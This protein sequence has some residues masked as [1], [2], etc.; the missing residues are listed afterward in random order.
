MMCGPG[1]PQAKRIKTPAQSVDLFPTIVEGAGGSGA[2]EPGQHGRSLWEIARGA[3]IDRTVFAEFHASASKNAS[4]LWRD[5][6]DKLIYHV[7]SRPQ[8][9]DLGEDPTEGVDLGETDAGLARARKLES[10]LRRMLDPEAVDAQAKADQLAMLER[11]GGEAQVREEPTIV[12]TPPP[13]AE[14]TL[15]PG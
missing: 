5:G 6:S 4:Y 12:F 11:H 13:G 8:F 10:V 7:D 3:E 2:P 9:Y 15:E 14:P 1:L